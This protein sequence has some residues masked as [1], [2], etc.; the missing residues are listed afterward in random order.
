LLLLALAA[1][2]DEPKPS[3]GDGSIIG[4]RTQDIRPMGV[5]MPPGARIADTKITAKDPITLQGNVYV[6]QIDRLATLEIEHALN[7]YE[8]MNDRY[9]KDYQE[10]M[11]EIIKANNIALPKLPV[12]QEYRYDEKEHKLVIIENPALKA[13]GAPAPGR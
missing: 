9:P 6:T 10:F 8:A 2:C 12:Y 3:S 4:K 7:L 11:D 1:G 5:N 13:P